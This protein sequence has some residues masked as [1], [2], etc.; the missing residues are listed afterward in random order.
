MCIR[1]RLVGVGPGELVVA[2]STSVNLFKVLSAALALQRDDQPGRTVIV[3]AA[4]VALPPASDPAQALVWLLTEDAAE[5][6]KD[7]KLRQVI[8][9]HS[10][11]VAWPVYVGAE[12]ANQQTALWR[13]APRQVTI[14]PLRITGFS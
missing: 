9:R 3:S 7:W 10:D 11:F 13:Q 4:I 6:A 8:K 2:D 14:R 12:R 5:F 1:D